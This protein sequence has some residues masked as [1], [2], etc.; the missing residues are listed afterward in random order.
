MKML[1]RRRVLAISLF[2][3]AA[4]GGLLAIGGKAHAQTVATGTLTISGDAGDFV[5]Q[6]RSYSY[7]TSNGDQFSVNSTD[8]SGILIQVS[9]STT[10]SWSLIFGSSGTLAA[11]TYTHAFEQG[12]R[13]DVQ[14]EGRGCGTTTGSFTVL[15]AVFG[16]Q[17]YVQ[18]FDATFVQ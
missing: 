6:G 7:S 2:L 11:G 15:D 17:G 4:V 16:P 13:L 10:D 8:G 12:A 18:R 14:G 5:T 9:V 1:W 3:A